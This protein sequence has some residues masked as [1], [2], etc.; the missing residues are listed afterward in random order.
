MQEGN[1]VHEGLSTSAWCSNVLTSTSYHHSKEAASEE[2]EEIWF[3]GQ[4][5]GT[6]GGFRS[7]IHKEWNKG[8]RVF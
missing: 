7:P 3:A 6:I 1:N 5:E 8:V 4:E 2:E